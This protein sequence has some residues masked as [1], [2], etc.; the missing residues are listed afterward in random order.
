MDNRFDQLTCSTRVAERNTILAKE[1]PEWK[2]GGWSANRER[3]D[4]MREQDVMR[5]EQE[6][7]DKRFHLEALANMLKEFKEDVEGKAEAIRAYAQEHDLDSMIDFC[8][9][10]SDSVDRMLESD[11]V[12]AAF[13]WMHSDHSC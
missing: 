7:V 3:S 13:K 9:W 6:V 5:Q 8:P 1:V 11:P 2:E 4:I 10:D 12:S